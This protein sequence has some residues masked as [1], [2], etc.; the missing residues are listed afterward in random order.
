MAA[1]HQDD[2]MLAVALH[3]DPEIIAQEGWEVRNIFPH[4]DE[5]QIN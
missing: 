2:D 4:L 5:T 3:C 1:Q